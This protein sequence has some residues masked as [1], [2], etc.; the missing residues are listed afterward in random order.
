[1]T[2]TDGIVGRNSVQAVL[3]GITVPQDQVRQLIDVRDGVVHVGYLD[4]KDTQ[5]I[6]ASRF[7]T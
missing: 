4:E 3:R 1:M 6:L 2:W 7:G 5:Q